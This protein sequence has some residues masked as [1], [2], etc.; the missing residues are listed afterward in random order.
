MWVW[1]QAI[2]R[3]LRF[4]VPFC[5]NVFFFAMINEIHWAFPLR[6]I[7]QKSRH[8]L[9]P[10]SR[11]TAMAW[12]AMEQ[13]QSTEPEKKHGKPKFL[14]WRVMTGGDTD[15]MIARFQ[16]HI[17]FKYKVYIYATPMRGLD[18]VGLRRRFLIFHHPFQDFPWSPTIG[19]HSRSRMESPSV[20]FGSGYF[21]SPGPRIM[22]SYKW[23]NLFESIY[24][25]SFGSLNHL[26]WLSTN[27]WVHAL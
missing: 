8:H 26:M 18:G 3:S 13:N 10:H 14:H 22:P 2:G 11:S 24:N 21:S 16:V 9:H 1:I 15:T 6:D 25:K 20:Y 23:F 27:H 5:I 12:E 4:F 17:L 7:C 19:D